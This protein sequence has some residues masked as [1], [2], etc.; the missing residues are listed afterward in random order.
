MNG[1]RKKPTIFEL[2][3]VSCLL[4][5]LTITVAGLQNKEVLFVTDAPMS[6]SMSIIYRD[7]ASIS[8]ESINYGSINTSISNESTSNAS[9]I[10]ASTITHP[11]ATHPSVMHLLTARIS[12]KQSYLMFQLK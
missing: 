2:F 9:T 11:S 5:G 3:F 12:Q 1:L 4:L 7:N 6:D 10:N 8:N